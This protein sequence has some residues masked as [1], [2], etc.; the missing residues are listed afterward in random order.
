M[1]REGESI[2]WEV[3]PSEG[4]RTGV[5]VE[6]GEVKLSDSLPIALCAPTLYELCKASKQAKSTFISSACACVY[7]RS[8]VFAN[9]FSMLLLFLAES[10]RTNERKQTYKRTT[11][12][13]ARMPD[14]LHWRFRDF[15]QKMIPSFNTSY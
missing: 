5:K 9:T 14:L 13:S 1:G 12:I 11:L 3:A 8:F 2:E 6:K 10:E 15:E 4:G 7:V